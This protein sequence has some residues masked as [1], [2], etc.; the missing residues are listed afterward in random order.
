MKKSI[1]SKIY[2][3]IYTNVKRIGAPYLMENF[4]RWQSLKGAYN[5]ERIFLIANGPSL[6][7]TPLY[8][9]KNEKTIMFNR[10]I[11]MLERLNYIPTF[12]MISDGLV[13]QTIKEDINFFVRNCKNVFVPDINKGDLVDFTKFVPFKENKNVLYMYEEPKK[14]SHMLPFMNVGGTVIVAAFQVLKYLGFSEVIVVGN[15]MNY[16]I[17]NTAQVISEEKRKGN[18]YQDVKSQADDDPNHFDPRY[19]G[20]GKEYHQPTDVIMRKIL[21]SLERVNRIYNRAG[22]KVINAGYNSMVQCFPKRDFYE[23]LGY[24]QEQ[25]DA[26]FEDLLLSLG[27]TSIEAFLDKSISV[28][29]LW[30]DDWDVVAAPLEKATEFVKVKIME[31]LPIGPYNNHI[32]FI[33]RKLINR[34]NNQ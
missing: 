15:D 26:L 31:Y 27:F 23:T 18:M 2:R 1:I 9:L 13:G 7:I 8:L 11:L 5:G 14:F 19:F 22:I 4:K 28:E 24:T 34:N 17:H 25:I 29:T 10:I 33:N 6:N 30:T 16:V 12:Y 3:L 32:Y 21:R 20:K